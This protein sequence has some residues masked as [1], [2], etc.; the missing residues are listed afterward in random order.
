MSFS[1]EMPVLW[2]GSVCSLVKENI[3]ALILLLELVLH[4]DL[5]IQLK[6]TKIKVAEVDT[7]SS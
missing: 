1:Q 2:K 3:S 5:E 7:F 4:P 6:N